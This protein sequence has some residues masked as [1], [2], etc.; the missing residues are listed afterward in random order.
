M[1]HTTAPP[2][3]RSMKLLTATL[4]VGLWLCLAATALP[5]DNLPPR[6]PQ[7]LP[8]PGPSS[9]PVAPLPGDAPAADVPPSR[10]PQG[11]PGPGPSPPVA[12]S[13]E[14]GLAP[15][16][17]GLSPFTILLITLGG[18][19]ALTGVAYIATRAA[20]HRRAVN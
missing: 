2:P 1:D 19:L 9:P 5:S 6:G 3:G 4:V 8:G 11:L 16:D 7:G 20:Q 12:P 15:P 18:T 13:P 10:G 17:E 14:L